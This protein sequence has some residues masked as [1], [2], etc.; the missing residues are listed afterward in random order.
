MNT[1]PK[2]FIKKYGAEP[3]P[4]K[5]GDSRVK[6]GPYS[7]SPSVDCRVIAEELYQ[8]MIRIVNKWDELDELNT[9]L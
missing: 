9:D 5:A 3:I 2:R 8:E 6:L 1:Y 4:I 7:K